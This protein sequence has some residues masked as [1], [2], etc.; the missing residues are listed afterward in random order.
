MADSPIRAITFMNF[1]IFESFRDLIK[2]ATEVMASIATFP[3]PVR[4]GSTSY[5]VLISG[6]ARGNSPKISSFVVF[7][8]VLKTVLYHPLER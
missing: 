3:E 1:R 2:V 6:V 7:S 8:I 5:E 4:F